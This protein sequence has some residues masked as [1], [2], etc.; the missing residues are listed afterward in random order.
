M[1][2]Q[3]KKLTGTN[4]RGKWWR[5][6]LFSFWGDNSLKRKEALINLSKSE[7]LKLC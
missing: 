2:V 7:I 3:R 6:V 1:L 4:G 5:V